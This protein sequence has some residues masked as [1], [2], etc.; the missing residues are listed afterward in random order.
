MTFELGR[1]RVG[2]YLPNPS[3]IRRSVLKREAL[4][5]LVGDKRWGWRLL[6]RQIP[7][8]PVT[9]AWLG[10]RRLP[11][12]NGLSS[13]HLMRRSTVVILRHGR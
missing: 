12:M 1:L 10:R 13:R 2:G 4:E 11:R 8:S 3:V 5:F 9:I 6:G 7:L